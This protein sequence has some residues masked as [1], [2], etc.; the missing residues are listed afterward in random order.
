MCHKLVDPVPCCSKGSSEQA[1]CVE[2]HHND[3]NVVLAMP[4]AWAPFCSHASTKRAVGQCVSASNFAAHLLPAHQP[5]AE[6]TSSAPWHLY[7]AERHDE[8]TMHVPSGILRTA[9][10]AHSCAQ[11]NMCRTVEQTRW[12]RFHAS[13]LCHY[14]AFLENHTSEVCKVCSAK[15]RCGKARQAFAPAPPSRGEA[16]DALRPLIQHCMRR[17]YCC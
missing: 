4:S 9:C 8:I 6:L 11:G 7:T 3:R 12:I 1:F 13:A 2:A 10:V 14:P 16:R 15:K 17:P 5:Q